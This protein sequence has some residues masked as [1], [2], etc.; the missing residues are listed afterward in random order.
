MTI[1]LILVLLILIL[2]LIAFDVATDQDEG[3]LCQLI[4]KRRNKQKAKQAKK[5]VKG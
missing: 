3:S 2:L 4:K 5:K 1:D